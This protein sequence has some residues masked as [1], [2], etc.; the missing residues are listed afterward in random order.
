MGQRTGEAPA[1]DAFFDE[2]P[3]MAVVTDA[4]GRIQRANAAFIEELGYSVDEILAA[5]IGALVNPDDRDLVDRGLASLDAA[6]AKTSFTAR[7]QQ[8]DGATRWF[9]FW[10]SRSGRPGVVFMTAAD[11]TQSKADE[12]ARR[13]N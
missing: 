12:D 10:C 3:L 2:C 5:S 4:D 9:R 7:V 6:G 1:V 8:K 13:A 11:V